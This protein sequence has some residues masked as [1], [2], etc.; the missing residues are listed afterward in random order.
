MLYSFM[1][2]ED[3]MIARDTQYNKQN[4]Y[5][6][7]NNAPTKLVESKNRKQHKNG[8]QINL[9]SNDV[10]NRIYIQSK[11]NNCFFQDDC[12]IVPN[13]YEKMNCKDF[14]KKLKN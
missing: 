2:T 7:L 10:H 12:N 11:C 14:T 8:K 4:R 1:L 9:L 13:I 6:I 3:K 5:Y